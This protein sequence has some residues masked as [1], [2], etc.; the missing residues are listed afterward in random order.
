MDPFTQT[1]RQEQ[2]AM[3]GDA[4]SKLMAPGPAG[5]SQRYET[6]NRMRQLWGQILPPE[7]AQHCRV[8]DFSQGQ[9][10]VEADSPSYMYELRISSQQLVGFL[11]QAYP[12]AK[13]RAIKVILTR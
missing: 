13:V 3:L 5:L 6:A 7:L 4:L 12:A 9:M 1:K 2:P 10:T 11:R 8:V